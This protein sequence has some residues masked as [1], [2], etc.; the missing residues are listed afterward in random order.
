MP[1]PWSES[2]EVNLAYLVDAFGHTDDIS[3]QRLQL[4]PVEFAI[5]SALGLVDAG[6]LARQVIL[7]LQQAALVGRLGKRLD[8]KP[9]FAAGQM[10]QVNNADV[11]AVELFSGSALILGDGVTTV[12]SVSVPGFVKRGVVKP[13]TEPTAMGPQEAFTET[14]VDNLALLRRSLRTRDLQVIRYSIGTVTQTPVFLLYLDRIAPDD[15]VRTVRERI[16]RVNVDAIIGSRSLAERI[17]DRPWSPF[18][19]VRMT[20]RVDKAVSALLEGSVLV[21]V[22]RT[23]RGLLLPGTFWDFFSL[24]Q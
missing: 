19:T 20:E 9:P 5:V 1:Q 11:A 8:L 18:P 16:E 2:L 15:I 21:L 12:W 23:P 7:P 14:I 22:D 10:S 4:G 6:E 13:E 3:V 24:L 17:G